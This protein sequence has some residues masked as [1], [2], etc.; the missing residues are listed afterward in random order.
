[1][2]E[3]SDEIH[4]CIERKDFSKFPWHNLNGLK[5]ESSLQEYFGTFVN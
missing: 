5:Y 2:S 4:L 1:M 3:N